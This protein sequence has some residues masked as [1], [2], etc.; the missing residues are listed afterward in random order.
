[1]R[2]VGPA[3]TGDSILC[4]L[5][6]VTPVMASTRPTPTTSAT[7]TSAALRGRNTAVTCGIA[8][9]SRRRADGAALR[10]PEHIDLGR[11][12]LLQ[13]HVRGATDVPDA[14]EPGCDQLC[15]AGSD[16]DEPLGAWHQ[17]HD[18]EDPYQGPS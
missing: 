2:V 11:P 18:S 3:R 14:D 6:M 13:A 1:M 8:A 5:V 10:S 7:A 17:G 15:R 4:R 12:R 9:Q 16:G